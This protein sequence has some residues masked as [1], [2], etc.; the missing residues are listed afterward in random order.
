MEQTLGK[1][2]QLCRKSLGL[3]QDQ[4]AEKLGVTAQAVSKWENDQSC[5]D[6]AM[7]PKLAEIFG[8]STDALLG[9][10]T[11]PVHEATI[12]NKA[13]EENEP[14]GIHVQKGNWEFHYENGRRGGLFFALLVL[15]VGSLTMLSEALS[16]DV[17][18]WS[19]MWPTALLVFGLQGLFSKFS[20]FSLGSTL[21]GGYFLLDNLNIITLDLGDMIWPAIVILWG[22]SLLA[23]ALRKPKKPKY[24]FIHNNN[25][26][27]APVRDFDLEE[28]SFDID[29]S[30]GE[31]SYDIPLSM[32][33]KGNI[34]CSFGEVVVDLS[35]CEEVAKNCSIDADCSFG[36]LCLRVPK[37]FLVRPA[38]S[39]FC[40]SVNVVGQPDSNPMGTIILDADVSF[41]EITI[42]YI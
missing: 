35:E 38:E 32:L 8:T 5:P 36:E 23:D 25:T 17:S 15:A 33:R 18:F 7:L 37:K 13:K 16:W 24:K 11:E 27:H 28:D 10:Q 20:F 4:L 22:L 31:A 26:N 1:R 39:T 40:A 30:F 34:D 3:T 41:G 42:E 29:V 2:I 14:E 6:I 9:Y 12:E 21:F 19:I